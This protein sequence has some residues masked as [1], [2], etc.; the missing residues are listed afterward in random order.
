MKL[1]PRVVGLLLVPPLMWS[2]N[3][4]VGR[5][6]ADTITPL[7]LNAVRW[8]SALLVLL[9]LGWGAVS[10]P[11]R[12]A[13]CR[14]RWRPLALLGLLGVGAYNALQYHALRTSSPINVTLIAAS[15]PL[16]MLL[17]GTVFHRERVRGPQALGALLSIAGVVTVLVR[18]ELSQIGS[19]HFVA[20]DLWML[21]A[22][23]SWALYSWELA[24]PS[25]LL[26]GEQ[27]PNWT[28][29]EFLLVQTLF[30]IAWG[31]AAAAAEHAL[32]A[33]WPAASPKLLWALPFLAIGPSIL[34]YRCWGLGV[35]AVGPAVAGFFSNL[36]PLFAA[37]LSALWLGV[38]PQPFHA[39]AFALIVA[40][41]AVSNRR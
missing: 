35:A 24:R 1:T 2:C 33:P 6:L 13:E 22:S 34:A 9:P 21:L 37:L 29:A 4:L 26:S 36:T 11:A 7:L 31:T 27:R 38:P 5:L 40:G 41:I 25:A 20:G 28:W 8:W 16:W 12:R 30:G 18:G 23:L 3:A 14:K 19:I 10:T 39:A 15:T 32:G 17:L